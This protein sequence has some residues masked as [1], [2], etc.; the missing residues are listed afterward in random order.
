MSWPFRRVVC[1]NCGEEN[2]A[3]IGYYHAPEYDHVRI[4]ACE[5]CKHYIKAVDL[6]RYGLAVPLVDEVAAAAL[7]LWVRERGYIKIELNLLGV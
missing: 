5:I 7:D 2:P 4:E 3:N 1:A 6:T